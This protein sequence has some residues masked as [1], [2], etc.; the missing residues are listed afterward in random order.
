[1]NRPIVP[2]EANQKVSLVPYDIISPSKTLTY[3]KVES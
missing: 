1:M 3:S 2:V